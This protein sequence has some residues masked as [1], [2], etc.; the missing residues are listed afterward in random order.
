[1]NF[2]EIKTLYEGPPIRL[3]PLKL[4][5][6][7]EFSTRPGVRQ[8]A[9]ENFLMTVHHNLEPSRAFLNLIRDVRAYRWDDVTANAI[10]D[11][12]LAACIFPEEEE[13]D[14]E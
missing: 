1:M 3:R 10:I 6:I 2:Q 5:E 7:K 8:V 13:E 12:I 4:S 9:V 14:E 11:G